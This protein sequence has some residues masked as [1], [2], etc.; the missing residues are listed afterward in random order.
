MGTNSQ[1]TE[2]QA[3]WLDW[4]FFLYVHTFPNNYDNISENYLV[5]ISCSFTTSF[6]WNENSNSAKLLDEK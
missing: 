5:G 1:F 3:Q 6:V 2:N 4:N